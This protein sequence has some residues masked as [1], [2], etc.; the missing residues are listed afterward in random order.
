MRTMQSLRTEK[1]MAPV[2]GGER[3]WEEPVCFFEDAGGDIKGG[4]LLYTPNKITSVINYDA[5]IVY[6]EHIDYEVTQDGIRLTEGSNIPVLKR[7][8]YI[9]AFTGEPGTDWLCLPEKEHF[10]HILADIV[11]FQILVTYETDSDSVEAEVCPAAWTGCVPAKQG[12]KL[13]N[14]YDKLEK[15]E[16][17]HVVFYGDSITAG[18]EASGADEWAVD[19]Y[20]LEP[21]RIHFERYPKMPVWAQLVAEQLKS[22]FPNVDITKDNLSAGGSTAQWGLEHVNELFDR[23]AKPDLVFVGFGM[24]CMWDAPEVFIGYIRG[25][26]EELRKRNPDCEFVLYPAM[27]ANP[28]MAAYQHDNMSIYEAALEE[29]AASQPGV[30]AAPV[31]SMFR[32]LINRGKEYYEISG[33]AVNHPNDFSIRLYAQVIWETICR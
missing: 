3:M 20:S 26:L 31:H 32:E 13:V 11:Q 6:E 19:M 12:V 25:I 15:G 29:F 18:W 23:V 9:G 21:M 7:D 1:W 5:S 2:W 22:C 33:N 17:L 30:I 4:K 14:T 8:A 28:E 16:P 24:N 27:V 10:V